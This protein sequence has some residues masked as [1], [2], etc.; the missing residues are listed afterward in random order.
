MSY[1]F[2]DFYG[3]DQIHVGIDDVSE[4]SNPFDVNRP[5]GVKTINTRETRLMNKIKH[6][7]PSCERKQELATEKPDFF[8]KD[9]MYETNRRNN[10]RK[11]IELKY[12]GNREV[13]DKPDCKSEHFN[14]SPS[15]PRNKPQPNTESVNEQLKLIY[16]DM[17][18][19]EK[20]NNILILF[21]FFL[22]VVVLVQY[23][24][25]NHIT[26]PMQYFMMP[27]NSGV[28]VASVNTN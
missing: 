26:Q 3:S 4:Y 22:A 21:I 15:K 19:L 18:E 23:S 13:R 24:K 10:I 28:K 20:K 7:T 2:G 17:L 8:T 6:Y 16:V 12:F 1:E 25:L 27:G 9:G 5:G 11:N 14:K